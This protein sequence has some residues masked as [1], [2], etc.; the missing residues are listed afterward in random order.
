MQILSDR[1]DYLIIQF[2]FQSFNLSLCP[3]LWRPLHSLSTANERIKYFKC[4]PL[5]ILIQMFL[6]GIFVWMFSKHIS[7]FRFFLQV[8]ILVKLSNFNTILPLY[9]LNIAS[10]KACTMDP[11]LFSQNYM[12]KLIFVGFT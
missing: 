9:K 4:I 12:K 10:I 8:T 3:K 5:N 6:F 1:N 11:D 2:Q 7:Y